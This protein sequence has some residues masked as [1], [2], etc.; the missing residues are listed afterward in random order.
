MET[1]K[2]NHYVLFQFTP[3]REGRQ[4]HSVIGDS[5]EDFNSRPSAR[6]DTC[7]LL[8]MSSSSISIH[9]PPRGATSRPCAV[10]QAAYKISIHAPPRGAT[11]MHRSHLGRLVFQFTPLR[12]GRPGQPPAERR[13]NY[14]SIHAPPRGATHP[15]I[16]PAYDTQSI[17][18]HAPPRGATSASRSSL[19]HH[20]FQFTPL[21]EGRPYAA[22]QTALELHFNSRP[23]ARG[24]T[25]ATAAS[26]VTKISIH[27]PPRGATPKS[28]DLSCTAF[29]FNSR[30]S[31]RGDETEA[32]VIVRNQI[33]I[34][35]PPRGA[36]F[37]LGAIRAGAGFQFTPL[38]EG[39]RRF[40]PCGK[41]LLDFNSRPSARGDELSAFFVP[42]KR[43][44]NS[45]PSARGDFRAET[46][47]IMQGKFQFTP[48][49][50]GRHYNH[51]C[52]K[53][54]IDFNSRPSARGDRCFSA[55]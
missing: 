38:R 20:E 47:L 55:R 9:A 24:D 4:W 35:A 39:R 41:L 53:A 13:N 11:R 25:I 26:N 28:A 36:T 17:S 5:R 2:G 16:R 52:K 19:W 8:S 21:R 45:R 44:F 15:Y 40:V 1:H 50:E 23:S 37:G 31:A 34:H 29:H 42:E 32:P 49:R 46:E 27:A 18:I 51:R 14:I 30:P 54:S 3:L 43:Y 33:S 22:R 7:S 6:G 12:E 48:L 10:H